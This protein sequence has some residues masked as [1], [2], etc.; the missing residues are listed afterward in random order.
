LR[1]TL[2]QLEKDDILAKVTEP[3]SWVSSMVVVPKKD[4][5]LRLCLDP[6]DLNRAVQRE[7]YPLP[8]IEDVAVRFHK[9]RLFTV[10]DVRQGFWHIVL[11]QES[12]YLT[13]FNT[14]FGRYR[15]KRLPFGISSA[16]EVFQRRMHQLIEGLR[17][18]E[19]IADDFCVVG[20]GETD[21]EAA[22]DHDRNLHAFLQRCSE[23]NV[24]L[25]D[26]KF[27]LRQS[28]VPFIGHVASNRGLQVS[29]DKVRAI[30]DMPVPTDV[31]AVQRFLGA[32]QYLAK[33]LP[34]L[35]E[36]TGPL[37]ELTRSD[38]VWFWGHSQSKAFEDIKVSLSSTPVLRYYSLD[39]PVEIQCDS[40]SHGI[41]A[42]LLQRG[43]PVMFASRALSSAE[44]RYAQ[45]E[46][47]LLA[48]FFAC[49]KFDMYIFGRSNVLVETDHK[50]L[51]MIFK[52]R[53]CDVPT[54]LQRMLLILQ[55]YDLCV[56][57]KKGTE[58]Y[59]ADLLSRAHLSNVQQSSFVS[60]LEVT[61]HRDV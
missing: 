38:S 37:R 36:M 45:I 57:Y 46:K 15:W 31:K 35:S 19:V 12:S 14:P 55:K 3:T 39:D 4:G 22:V 8:V 5:S 9:A 26:K 33:F 17:G 58:M 52:K 47:E 48:I 56:V 59:L 16:P 11:G 2:D 21:E 44:T 54:R 49:T 30:L 24:K 51:E 28:E 41:G 20:Y 25:N 13:T 10:L 40:S 53:L 27:Q 29:A 32:V 61:D 34:R 42:V 7:H 60:T 1:N 43:Q 23:C 6:K 18:I 50:P